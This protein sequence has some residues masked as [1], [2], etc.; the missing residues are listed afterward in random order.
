MLPVETKERGVDV[1]AV[2]I[3]ESSDN[4]VLLIKRPENLRTFPGIWVPP[5]GHV[6]FGEQVGCL[7]LGN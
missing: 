7:S 4:R 2:T 6:E 1:G 3:V 5:G